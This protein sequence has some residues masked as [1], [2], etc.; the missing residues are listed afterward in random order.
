M[1]KAALIVSI[2]LLAG[3]VGSN[4]GSGKANPGPDVRTVSLTRVVRIPIQTLNPGTSKE[5][6]KVD[7]AALLISPGAADELPEGPNGFDVLDDGSLLITDPLRHQVSVFDGEGKFLRAWKL[8]FAADSLTVDARG[9][10]VVR[11]ANTEQLH[12]FDRDGRPRPQEHEVLPEVQET[13]V[14]SA[15]AGTV[16]P[17]AKRNSRSVALSIQFERPGSTLL[18]LESLATDSEGNNF[19]ALEATTGSA[20]DETIG[21]DKYVRR[22]SAAGA[23]ANEIADIPLDYYVPPMDELRVRHGVVYQLFTTN[24]EVR[25]NVWNTN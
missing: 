2:L 7:P 14:I 8:G 21:V 9:L 13:R 1:V 17:S 20:S 16:I 23:L 25:I 18:S 4:A 11:E 10:I 24:S 19:V 5:P 3:L 6:A 12:V 22:Y 15:T